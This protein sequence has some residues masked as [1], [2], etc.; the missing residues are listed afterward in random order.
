MFTHIYI[1]YFCFV[2]MNSSF[3]LLFFVFFG[4]LDAG[5]SYVNITSCANDPVS[6]G[7]WRLNQNIIT[8]GDCLRIS[9]ND[10]TLDCRG[11]NVSGDGGNGDAGIYTTNNLKNLTIKNCGIY[12]FQYGIDLGFI[13]DSSIINITAN[14]HKSVAVYLTSSNSI[15]IINSTLNYNGNGGSFEGGLELR[16]SNNNIISNLNSNYNDGYGILFFQ[17]SSNN[18]F[19][20]INTINNSI[21]GVDIRQDNYN[22]SF[23]NLTSNYNNISGVRLYSDINLIKNSNIKYNGRGGTF[24]AGVKYETTSGSSPRTH[25]NILKNSVI[26]YNDPYGIFLHGYSVN[27]SIFSN[28]ILNNLNEDI[29]F[30]IYSGYK[31]ENN[32]FYLNKLNSTKIGSSDWSNSAYLNQFNS[33]SQGN[34][35]IDYIN[36]SYI[37]FDE[38]YNNLTCDHFP[39]VYIL[40]DTQNNYNTFPAVA[41]FST[42]VVLLVIFGSF[43]F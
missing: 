27:N 43:L 32:V 28:L 42:V 14:G 7:E 36:E 13:N 30:H 34:Y 12:T 3:L 24:H 35:Y 10:V 17:A 33:S 29:Y 4:V 25:N 18:S 20:N 16:T 2:V 23:N 41:M 40:S 31:P 8:T 38:A 39:S 21:T 15:S 11:F 26:E 1:N 9:A 6:A 19:N 22:N 37:C 5:F